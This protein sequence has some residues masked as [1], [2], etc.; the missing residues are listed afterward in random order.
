MYEDIY[1]LLSLLLFMFFIITS[2][3]STIFYILIKRATKPLGRLTKAVKEFS[4]NSS[5]KK[6]NFTTKDEVDELFNTFN[7]MSKTISNHT[8]ILD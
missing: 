6:F 1:K 8:K 5:E 4:K 2:I 7:T 3:L